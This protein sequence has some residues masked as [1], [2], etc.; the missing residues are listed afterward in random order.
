MK[1]IFRFFLFIFFISSSLYLCSNVYADWVCECIE[2]PHWFSGWIPDRCLWISGQ[3]VWIL[4][5]GG[6]QLKLYYK[7]QGDWELEVPYDNAVSNVSMSVESPDRLHVGFCDETAK[8]LKYALK[9]EDQWIIETVDETSAD[10]FHVSIAHNDEGY[11]VIAY[12]ADGGDAGLHAALKSEFGWTIQEI[13]PAPSVGKFPAIAQ[14]QTGKTHILYFDDANNKFKHCKFVA[15]SWE[16]EEI[17]DIADNAAAYSSL[18]FS[19]EDVLN[20][21]LYEDC[22]AVPFGTGKAMSNISY[23]VKNGTV[24]EFELVDSFSESADSEFVPTVG[25]ALDSSEE[26]ALV[27]GNRETCIKY[28]ERTLGAWTI[29]E[30][31]ADAYSYAYGCLDFTPDDAPAVAFLSNTDAYLKTGVKTSGEWSL[32]AIEK[33]EEWTGKAKINLDDDGKAHIAYRQENAA[34]RFGLL[35]ESGWVIETV[36]GFTPTGTSICLFSGSGEYPE[37]IYSIETDSGEDKTSELKYGVRLPGAWNIDIIGGIFTNDLTAERFEGKEYAGYV[38]GNTLFRLFKDAGSWSVKLV[39]SNAAEDTKKVSIAVESAE[40][41]YLGFK[42]DEPPAMAV[43]RCDSGDWTVEVI[44]Q[45]KGE[46][47]DY[48]SMAVSDAGDIYLAY[49]DDASG[50]K[51]AVNDAG[52]WTIHVVDAAPAEY[53]PSVDIDQNDKPALIYS[54]SDRT[55]LYYMKYEG[56]EWAEPLILDAE[57]DVSENFD[58]VMDDDDFPKILYGN[59]S[60]RS[61]KVIRWAT[62]TPTATCSPTYSPT[63]TLSPTLSPSFSPTVTPTLMT[64]TPTPSFSPTRTPTSTPVPPTS[65][66]TSTP[67]VDREAPFILAAG[68]MDTSVTEEEGGDLSLLALTEGEDVEF[69]KVYYM[70]NDDPI[71]LDFT[72]TE[73]PGIEPP[74]GLY[75]LDIPNPGPCFLPGRYLLG[76]KAFDSNGNESDLWPYFTI[77]DRTQTG[78]QPSFRAEEKIMNT[79]SCLQKFRHAREETDIFVMAAGYYTTRWFDDAEESLT[80]IAWVNSVNET[81]SVE[82]YSGGKPLGLFLRDDEREG[83]WSAEDGIYT[84]CIDSID[85]GG[86]ESGQFLFE[87]AAQ[88]VGGEKSHL[89]PYLHVETENTPTPSPTRPHQETPVPSVSPTPSPTQSFHLLLE[90]SPSFGGAPLQVHCEASVTGGEAGRFIWD[91]GDG[92]PVD[93]GT[94]SS[95]DHVYDCICDHTY[96]IKVYAERQDGPGYAEDSCTV[97]TFGNPPHVESQAVFCYVAENCTNETGDRLV[98]LRVDLTGMHAGDII[99]FLRWEPGMGE[100]FQEVELPYGGEPDYQFGWTYRCQPTYRGLLKFEINGICEVLA[101]F[102]CN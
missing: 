79:I 28:A 98:C 31:D 66:P 45:G 51:L 85:T 27:Y 55:G 68:W 23:F 43:A 100:F 88:D 33:H 87:I 69:V 54:A 63:F 1:V 49:G 95:M 8:V 19:S 60:Q 74:F 50:L 35:E 64:P 17:C 99:G 11:A 4:C 29:D 78:S 42:Q 37:I 56:L 5:T 75:T 15:L 46:I 47:G 44:D 10:V 62:R 101:E 14:D 18:I 80:I 67:Y 39:A 61:L 6:D 102:D 96:E 82:L 91:F 53:Y 24:W 52:N 84:F 32:E 90:C 13:E 58:M 65:T 72:L 97:E 12:Y 77:E 16:I 86:M 57:H 3:N 81:E 93:S 92:P 7:N 2:C 34:L 70:E 26:P 38:S 89:W 73:V 25:L 21:V 20:G 41:Y 30:I 22:S 9:S 40:K 59:E 36:D 76:L 83:D 71:D 94:V 48:S